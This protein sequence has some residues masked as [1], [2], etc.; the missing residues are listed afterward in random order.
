MTSKL[1][2][3]LYLILDQRPVS[4]RSCFSVGCGR[5]VYRIIQLPMKRTQPDR[6]ALTFISD[7]RSYW[8][9]NKDK[10]SVFNIK[11]RNEALTPAFV[12]F[13]DRINIFNLLLMLI[14][15]KWFV[16]LICHHW[17]TQ[18]GKSS[19]SFKSVP[20]DLNPFSIFTFSSDLNNNKNKNFF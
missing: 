13:D 17:E 8:W 20:W 9:S 16:V 14:S 3:F 12:T 10:M 15:G 19:P 1:Y 4:Q 7:K 6:S 5:C 11:I 18:T 2:F